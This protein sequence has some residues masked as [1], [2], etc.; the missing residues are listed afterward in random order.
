VSAQGEAP[1]EQRPTVNDTLPGHGQHILYL[2]DEE[3]LVRLCRRKFETL[4]YRASGYTQADEA[5]AAVQA[6]PS[7]FDLVITDYNMPGLSGLKVAAAVRQLNPRVPIVLVSGFITQEL[8]QQARQAGVCRV[9]Y[10]PDTF[11]DLLK[12]LPELLAGGQ[13]E[14]SVSVPAQKR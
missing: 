9:L 8:E 11:T 4:G 7:G 5:L 1:A 3:I 10:K 6:L 13:A 14:E 12:I 2:D